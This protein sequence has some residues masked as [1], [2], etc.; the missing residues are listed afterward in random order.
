MMKKRTGTGE[1]PEGG[2]GMKLIPEERFSQIMQGEVETWL[3][4]LCA[5]GRLGG[6]LY[7]EI[8]PL[9][10]AKATVVISHGS[11]ENCEKFHEFIYYLLQEGYSCAV[12]DHR[13][14]GRSDREGKNPMVV[15]ISD[16]QRH[17]EDFHR[18]VHELVIPMSAGK[19]LYLYGHSMGGCIAAL[20]L[21]QWPED[22]S[23]AVLSAPMLGLDTGGLP[24]WAASAVCNA[25]IL[26]GKAE[27]KLWF[28]GDYNPEMPFEED[29][30]ASRARFQYYQEIRRGESAYQLSAAS[31]TWTREAIRAGARA[32][33]NAGKIQVPVLVFQAERDGYVSPKAQE[34]FVA[35][36]G[37]GRL[38]RVPGSK[39]EIYRSG[40]A[41]LK[42]YLTRV[43]T[44]FDGTAL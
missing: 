5:R 16:F 12:M 41:V 38:V 24:V 13:G 18:F 44:F 22:F 31:Y 43:F 7:Y 28:Q 3:S 25:M 39:H 29:G 20:Y 10:G 6:E 30:S 8:F 37:R 34:R 23:R 14:H 27:Q 11:T 21:E 19:P 4:G 26:L 32:V 36:L 42:G 17:A 15:H 9:P 1:G 40:N 33:K 2:G 35:R